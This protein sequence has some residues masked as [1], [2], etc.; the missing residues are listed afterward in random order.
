MQYE[1]ISI[2]YKG[3]TG[4]WT[5]WGGRRYG[6]VADRHD[7]EV[8]NIWYC[9][10]CNDPQPNDLSPFKFEYPEGEYIRVCAI[11]LSNGCEKLLERAKSD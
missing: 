3:I 10:S 4:Q 1:E 8:P 7:S 6:L 2:S 5:K 9:Q 11:C